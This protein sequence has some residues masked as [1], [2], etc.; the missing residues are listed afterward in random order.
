[1]G[2]FHPSPIA[3]ILKKFARLKANYHYPNAWPHVPGPPWPRAEMAWECG[4]SVGIMI[5]SMDANKF[6]FR[7]T[8]LSVICWNYSNYSWNFTLVTI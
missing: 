7:K 8:K 2:H 3:T 5:N 4:I 6:H 1:M